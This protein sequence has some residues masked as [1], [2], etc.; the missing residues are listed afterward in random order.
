MTFLFF[1]CQLAVD[2]G[3][4]GGT[5]AIATGSIAELVEYQRQYAKFEQ[6]KKERR[7]EIE[8]DEIERR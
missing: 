4:G 5:A 2:A 1:Q 3:K 6:A 8:L 7:K